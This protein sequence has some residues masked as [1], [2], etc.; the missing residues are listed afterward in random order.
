MRK[1][2]HEEYLQ[3]LFEKE[4]N[5]EPLEPYAGTHSKI[6]HRCIEGHEWSVKPTHILS[7]SGCPRCSR[8]YSSKTHEDYLKELFEKEIDFE[9][10]ETYINA[11]TKILHQCIEGHEWSVKPYN[12]LSGSGCP[13]CSRRKTHEEYVKALLEKEIN[14]EPLEPYVNMYTSILH[15]CSEGHEWSVRPSHIL[16][17]GGCPECYY[18][19]RTK[20]HEEYLE[21]LFEKEINFEP[22]ET[23]INANTKILHQCVEGHQWSAYPNLILRGSG[24]PECAKRGFNPQK[25]AIL[26]YLRVD[27]YYKVG[28]TNNTVEKRY[29]LKKDREK[30]TVLFEKYYE[31]G[32]DARDQEQAILK[33]FADYRIHVPELLKSGGNTEL[34]TEDVLQFDKK[35]P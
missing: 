23:Y 32:Q 15:R 10:L 34:F 7:G 24:C 9:P 12:I 3:E 35:G 18:K 19:R 16:Q 17:K 33:E 27:D 13:R 20:A 6:L 11:D 30:I 28:I 4:I 2:T 31:R 21:E 5:F 25:S 26:Y 14:F 22:V 8:L 29:E 1:K